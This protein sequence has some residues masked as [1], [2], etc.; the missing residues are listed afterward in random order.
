VKSTA[1]MAVKSILAS[2]FF[3]AIVSFL[4]GGIQITP[5]VSTLSHLSHDSVISTGFKL[6]A[7]L[8]AACLR[9]KQ[10]TFFPSS[11]HV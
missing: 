7:E 8:F 1:T 2:T 6:W 10:W 4:M 3:E 11:K 9:S 5:T